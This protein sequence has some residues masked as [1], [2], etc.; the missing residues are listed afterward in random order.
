MMHRRGT[1]IP[2]IPKP[3]PKEDLDVEHLIAPHHHDVRPEVVKPYENVMRPQLNRL[4]GTLRVEDGWKEVID[5]YAK[6]GVTSIAGA[7]ATAN[8]TLALA[9]AETRLLR[10]PGAVQL[11]L[12]IR[13]FSIA[14][15]TATLATLGSLDVYYQDLIGGQVIPL[16]NIQ[17]K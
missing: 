7:L 4:Y 5:N 8:V 3:E 9:N 14:L 11:Y 15:S 1:E 16:G 10:W 13:S 6:G 17:S 12:A 2:F